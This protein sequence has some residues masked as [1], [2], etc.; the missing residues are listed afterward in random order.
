MKVWLVAIAEPIPTP[1]SDSRL[2]RAGTIALY[3]AQRGHQVI[4]WSSNFDHVR[5]KHAFRPGVQIHVGA[6][7]EVR[8]LK[9]IGYPANVC[10]RRLLDHWLVGREFIKSIRGEPRPDL[11]ICSFPTIELSLACARYGKARNIPVIIDIRDLW[12]DAFAGFLP[13]VLSPLAKCV[14]WPWRRQARSALRDARSIIAV[15]RGYLDWALG[16]AGRAITPADAVFPH[17]YESCQP[18][19]RL[20]PGVEAPLVAKGI[21]P[22][23]QICWF[24]GTFGNSY[25]LDTVIDAARHLASVGCDTY[26]FV[27]SGDGPQGAAWRRR[28]EGLGNIVFTGWIERAQIAWLMSHAA[29]GLAAYRPNAAPF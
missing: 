10:V 11:I 3:L 15:S 4:W 28:A 25:D 2:L 26:Q 8:C 17:G 21:D 5:K 12:P 13:A 24:V 16:Y 22:T 18:S 14:L 7:L 20:V 23:R 19:E 9:S 27:F 29:V 6:Q 1:G